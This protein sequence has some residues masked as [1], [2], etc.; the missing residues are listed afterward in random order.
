MCRA[1]AA[2]RAVTRIQTPQMHKT[3]IAVW[4]ASYRARPGFE[5]P[6]ASTPLL[7]YANAARRP[8]RRLAL[9]RVTW[10]LFFESVTAL[11]MSLVSAMQSSMPSLVPFC[12]V[13]FGLLDGGFYLV[14]HFPEELCALPFSMVFRLTAQRSSAA[15]EVEASME[16][17]TNRPNSTERFMCFSLN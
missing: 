16:A 2:M 9:S 5:L 3:A 10:R 17:V 15:N 7:M 4:F 6:A 13:G 8:T 14:S 12:L 11:I 1:S